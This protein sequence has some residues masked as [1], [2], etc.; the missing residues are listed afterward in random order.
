VKIVE[1]SSPLR[2]AVVELHLAEHI[3]C[4]GVGRLAAFAF[5]GPADV[6]RVAVGDDDDVDLLALV[7]GRDQELGQ[8]A[9]RR[10]SGLAVAGIE[11][12]KFPAGIDDRVGEYG[13]ELGRRQPI[14]LGISLHGLGRLVGAE[15]RMRPVPHP[16]AVE[17]VGH[18]EAAEL[19]SV[20][21]GARYSP[22]TMFL[23]S[24]A[25]DHDRQ[26]INVNGGKAHALN[27]G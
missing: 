17:D 5:H 14:G 6:V 11:Q 15:G 18:L 1:V 26:T 9:G 22:S 8:L 7:A 10:H 20:D 2:R 12:D 3:T 16:V 25:S 27:G 4:V 24:S 19:E 13:L 21:C 23:A